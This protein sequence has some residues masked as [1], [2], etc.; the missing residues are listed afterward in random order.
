MNANKL[1]TLHQRPND[2]EISNTGNRIAFN[3]EKKT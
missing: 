3:N 1:T 2:V